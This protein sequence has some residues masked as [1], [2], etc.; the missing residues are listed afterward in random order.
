[1]GILQQLSKVNS[2]SLSLFKEENKKNLSY[3]IYAA[4][5]LYLNSGERSVRMTP[6]Y[7]APIAG[8]QNYIRSFD[9]EM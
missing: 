4:F 2:N 7:T 9:H 8:A 1:M 3:G 5:P 6:L